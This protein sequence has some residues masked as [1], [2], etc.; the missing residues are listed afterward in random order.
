MTVSCW[1]PSARRMLG[2]LYLLASGD[3]CLAGTSGRWSATDGAA[4]LVRVTVDGS[5][6]SDP[7]AWRV[8][9]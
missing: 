8:T 6:V 4:P 1:D 3:W 7:S 2:D 5:L 9:Q